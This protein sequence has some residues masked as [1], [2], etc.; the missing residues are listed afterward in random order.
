M[1]QSKGFRN[2]MERAILDHMFQNCL[3]SRLSHSV[4]VAII[5]LPISV[6]VLIQVSFYGKASLPF[7]EW[8]KSQAQSRMTKVRA[9]DPDTSWALAP[10]CQQSLQF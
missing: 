2:E 8:K 5:T 6:R 7:P 10:P 4:S 3:P 9:A 1:M